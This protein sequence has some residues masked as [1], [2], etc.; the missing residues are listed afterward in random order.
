ML[1]MSLEGMKDGM[2]AFL[3]DNVELTA[4]IVFALGFAESI[5]LV[6]LFIPST[7]LFL[8]IGGLHSAAG[9]QFWQVWL[10]GAAGA[11]IGDVVSYLV[12]RHFKNDVH[13]VWPFTRM[14]GLIPQG[15]AMFERWGFWSIVIGKF[16]GGLRPFI[17]VVAGMMDMPWLV[18]LMG[19]VL[20]SL[21]W[22]GVFLAPGY[23]VALLPW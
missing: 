23:G 20:S 16:F 11:A 17:P 15:R 5:A 10:A 12:G 13:K 4:L 1:T 14:P 18:F 19:S 6:S 3:R 22:A 21:V 9:G 8:A 2:L 7:I